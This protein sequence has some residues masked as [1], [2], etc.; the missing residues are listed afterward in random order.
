MKAAIGYLLLAALIYFGSRTEAPSPDL[1][2]QPYATSNSSGKLE[3][4]VAGPY[5]TYD[6][7]KFNAEKMTKGAIYYRVPTGCL[8]RGY[9]NP[10]VQWV[11][12]TVLGAGNFKCIAQMTNRETYDSP[13]YSPVLASYP[14]DHGD[15]WAC[16]FGG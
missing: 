10:Y 15:N 3:W 11:V 13:M 7:C 2:W 14:S 16:Y 4:L 6:E 8:Y 1:P 5:K 9:Q 12:N